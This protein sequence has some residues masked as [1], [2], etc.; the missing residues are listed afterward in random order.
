MT[1]PENAGF[2][3]ESEQVESFLRDFFVDG[4]NP[5][6]AYLRVTA[7]SCEVDEDAD[8]KTKAN[9][10]AKHLATAESHGGYGMKFLIS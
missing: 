2:K 5:G 10:V 1:I 7:E 3:I 9:K 8:I 6:I 4:L